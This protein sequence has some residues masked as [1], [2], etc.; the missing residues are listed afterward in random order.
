MEI[1]VLI[2]SQSPVIRLGLRAIFDQSAD[3][4]IVG[5]VENGL[6]AIRIT[7][8]HMPDILLTGL[9]LPDLAALELIVELERKKLPTQIVIFS[10]R[11][12]VEMVLACL[13]SGAKGY[14]LADEISEK[15]VEAIRAVMSGEVRLSSKVT[16]SLVEYAFQRG[17][18][19]DKLPLLPVKLTQR[20]QNVLELLVEGQTN[21]DIATTLVITENT[22]RHHLRIIY[23]KLGVRHRGEAIIWAMR[24][25]LGK[26]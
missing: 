20:E 1:R 17:P 16:S 11:A 21:A 18:D 26:E 10:R 23:S 3:I 5:E 13:N 6:E 14:L 15:I 19:E 4:M 7:E 22:V 9:E 8:K 24:H 25:G 12:P 2:A